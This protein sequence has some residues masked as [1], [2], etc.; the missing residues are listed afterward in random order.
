MR[1]KE[2]WEIAMSRRRQ[3]ALGS[4]RRNW[5]R[6]GWIFTNPGLALTRVVRGRNFFVDVPWATIRS[7]VGKDWTVVE[8]GAADGTDT[9]RLA[10]LVPAG[11][12]VAFEPMQELWVLCSER[13]ASMDNVVVE[14]YALDTNSGLRVMYA[15]DDGSSIT[16]SSSL[17]AP[18]LHS[19]LH[20]ETR[21]TTRRH[22][23]TISL[24]EYFESAVGEL[25]KFAW[26]DLQG[27]EMAVLMASPRVR[28][29]LQAI[30]MEV[31]RI[32]LYH[33]APLF[34]TVKR[35]MLDWGFS[36]TVNQVG[37]VAGNAL[38]SRQ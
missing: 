29:H 36:L 33:A 9:V 26:L 13:L 31:F 2:S 17:L 27:L 37:A 24:D 25:P 30:Y 35:Q 28:S 12:V 7:I 21:F 18:S 38:F 3:V 10:Q 34:P 6:L 20:P 11:K 14:R 23:E 22:V 4:I 19:D 32:P 8:A 1:T 16:G 15:S 5:I